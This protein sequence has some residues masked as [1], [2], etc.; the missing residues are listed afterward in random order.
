MPEMDLD[1]GDYRERKPKGWRWRLPWSHPDD[2]KMQFGMLLACAGALGFIYWNRE[3]FSAGILF[4]VAAVF[5]FVAG[6]MF[7]L[8][9]R[10]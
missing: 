5:A 6:I 4:G 3:Q 9:F 2:A 1:P 10:D 8:A 7:A